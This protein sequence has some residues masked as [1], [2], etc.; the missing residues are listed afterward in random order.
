MEK[1]ESFEKAVLKIALPVTIQSLLQS[2]FSVVDQ[3]M[4]GQLGS[5]S[6]AGIGL[7]GKFASLYSVVLA[8]IASAAGI[9]ISQYMGRKD[10]KSVSKSFYINMLLSIGL[11]A[12]FMILCIIFPEIIMSAYTKD[13]ITKTLA[14]KYIRILAISFLPM[15]IS[16]ILTMM[17]RCMEVAILPLYASIFALVLNTGL[18]YLLIFGKWIFPEMGVEGAALA[19]VAAQIISCVIILLFFIIYNN[20]HEIKLNITHYLKRIS[21]EQKTADSGQY[22][23]QYLKIL[24][25]LLICEFL[26]SLGENVYTAI[27][28]NIGTEACAAM[29]MTIPVLTIVIGALSGLSQASAILIGKSLG[30][31][32]YEQAYAESKK[33]MKY[34]LFA[35]IILSLMLAATASFYV[36]IYNVEPVVQEI[37]KRLLMVIAIISPVKVLNMILGGG[38]IRSGGKTKYTMWIDI[39]GTW[40]LGVPLGLLAAFVWKLPIEYVYFILSMEECVRLGISLIIFK[41]KTWMESIR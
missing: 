41:K 6:I 21:T 10:E 17:L 4:I 39:I 34:G 1:K 7:G 19:S 27:Y 18:N 2:S 31:K 22:G 8:A 15:A 13:V 40:G 12:V 35:S 33:L 16:S 36:K 28:G 23:R 38:I 9:M 37:T 26:W 32:K 11:A 24:C 29:T 14:V 25:P 20:K 30:A 3:V 5:N